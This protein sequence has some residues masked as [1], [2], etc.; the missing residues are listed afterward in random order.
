[1]S[2]TEP[3]VQD[4]RELS[5]LNDQHSHASHSGLHFKTCFLI[6]LVVTFGP[7]GNV[8]LSK[9]M[10]QIGPVTIHTAAQFLDV[11]TQI[12]TSGSI[13][14][15][16]ASQLTFFVAFMLVLSW[17]DY[18]YV[19]PATAISYGMVAL[20][21]HFALHESV[22]PMR[23]FGIFIICWGVLIVGHTHPRTTG[24]S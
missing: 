10:K 4:T 17:A 16:I 15:G 8:L 6:L 23:W 18:S 19:Q 7:L 24:H 5:H 3:T 2:P 20:L 11:F 12:F 9:G 22:S 21:G 1:M 14:L 13:W